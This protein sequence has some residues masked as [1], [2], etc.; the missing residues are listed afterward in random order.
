MFSAIIVMGLLVVDDVNNNYADQGVS[1]NTD[2]FDE[3]TDSSEE[4][5]NYSQDVYDKIG[6]SETD[7]GALLQAA[8]SG[9]RLTVIPFKV[10][11]NYINAV[12]TQLSIP[13]QVVAFL[14]GGMAILF[15][16]ALV[17]LIF[18]FIPFT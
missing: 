4:L 13:D 15:T 2:S 14:I 16:F 3:L 18:R 17:Y 11:G 10:A 1:I 9:L 5:Y 8:Y 12:A 6:Q 7:A